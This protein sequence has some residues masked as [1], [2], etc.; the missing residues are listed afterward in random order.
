MKFLLRIKGRY[1]AEYISKYVYLRHMALPAI[2][3]PFFQP[4]T[5]QKEFFPDDRDGLQDLL[6]TV[7]GNAA[8]FPSGANPYDLTDS[9]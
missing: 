9:G 6:Q 3:L 7:S 8:V 2:V 5:C 1:G 4:I